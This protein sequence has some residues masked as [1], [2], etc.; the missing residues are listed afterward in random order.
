MARKS[1]KGDNFQNEIGL[2]IGAVRLIKSAHQRYSGELFKKYRLTGQQLGALRITALSP[3]ISL[4]ELSR[5]MYLHISTCSG[6]VDRLEKKGYLR[7]IRSRDD[8]RVVSL[9]IT[10]RGGEIIKQTPVSGLGFLIQDIG[11]LPPDKIHRLCDGMKILMKLMRIE[12]KKAAAQSGR[13]GR[14]NKGKI[15]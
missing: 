13:P 12:D 9:K 2:I 10:R 8:R 11:K 6:I 3:E 15:S 7:R 14:S 1:K 4:G 5:R